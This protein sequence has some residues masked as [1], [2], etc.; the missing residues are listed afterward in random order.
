MGHK[1]LIACGALL[2]GGCNADDFGIGA[3]D[4]P[5]SAAV[6]SP[7]DG[8]PFEE[9]VGFVANGRSGTVVPLDLKHATLLSDQPG[10]PFVA[11]RKVATGDERQLGS[12]AVWAPSDTAV[13]VFVADLANDVLVEA[14]Y[15]VDMDPSPVT[16][17]LSASDPV[18]LD[19]D[20]SGESVGLEDI[21]LRAG[22]TTTED[23]SVEYNGETWWVFGSR[24]GKQNLHPEP[25]IA[26]CTDRRELCFTLSGQATSGDRFELSTD[27]G[28]VEHDLGG[29]ILGLARVPGADLLVAGVWDADAAQ[30]EIVFFDPAAGAEVG[31]ITPA[32]GAQPWRFAFDE[33]AATMFV[34]DARAPAVYI[35]TLDLADPG[36][37][38]WD[39]L[40]TAAPLADVAWA[41]DG[42]YHR[43]FA[44]LSAENRVDIYDLDSDTW[45]DANPFDDVI[46]G[47]DLR[48]PIV[49]LSA[50]VDPVRLQETT[51]W[52]VRREEIVVAV[53]TSD[54]SLRMIEAD[55]GCLAT[56]IEGPRVETSSGVEQVQWL[57][58]GSTSDP[59]LLAD[60]STARNVAVNTCGGVARTE[61]WTVLYDQGTG[62]WAVEG[63]RS[64]LQQQDAAEDERY[65][66][67]NGAI[68]FT[69]LAGNL[70]ST[71]GD[72]FFFTTVEGVLRVRD[73]PISDRDSVPMDLPG[74][75]VL[76][77]VDAGPTGGGWDVLDRRTYALIPVTNSD[78]VVNIR[79]SAWST[80]MVWR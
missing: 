45:L 37:S 49:G 25:N 1:P 43:L 19:E 66:A 30:G 68:S 39:T 27:A 3:F 59:K 57:D 33:G 53:T 15:I 18:F 60:S 58:A 17:T 77:Q 16:P 13:T 61:T 67:D 46:G 55:T 73:I 12:M 44:G 31:R 34:G 2:W 26:Y 80:E 10:S 23:W 40:E 52:G 9:P 54:G 24:S 79:L 36:A 75:P 50:S 76:F 4:S 69:I 51:S 56:D 78:R 48:A 21:E 5:V 11:P 8:G 41:S 32:L 64:G 72:A 7:S 6:L 63:S 35:V 38:A 62:G 14:P 22:Y 47:V 20:G 29:A 74:A 28:V 42:E 71:D 70:P 65:V